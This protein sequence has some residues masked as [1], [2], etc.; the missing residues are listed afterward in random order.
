M[1]TNLDSTEKIA[2]AVEGGM[3][4]Y[5]IKSNWPI[6]GIVNKIKERLGLISIK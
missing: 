2:E 3:H 1:L 5:L 4:E 6:D